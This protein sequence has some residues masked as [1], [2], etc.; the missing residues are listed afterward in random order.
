MR[1]HTSKP[2]KQ[3][4]SKRPLKKEHPQI[5]ARADLLFFAVLGCR[6]AEAR[7]GSLQQVGHMAS[8]SLGRWQ[9]LGATCH[10]SGKEPKDLGEPNDLGEAKAAKIWEKKLTIWELLSERYSS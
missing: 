3:N 10:A 5:P 7:R 9:P 8:H 6:V 4:N 2:L 1:I